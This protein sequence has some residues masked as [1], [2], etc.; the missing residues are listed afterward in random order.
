MSNLVE[1]VLDCRHPAGLA[2]FWGVALGWQV[3]P[4]DQA[5]VARL[6]TRGLIPETDPSVAVDSPGGSLVFFLQ[7][8]PE[9]KFGEPRTTRSPLSCRN[10]S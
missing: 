3:R 4:Y 6:A 10:E 9:G 1:I 8:V 5:E 2:R 7:E